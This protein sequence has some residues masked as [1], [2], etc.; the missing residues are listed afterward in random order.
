M[1]ELGHNVEGGG[2]AVERWFVTFNNI[3]YQNLA[4][5]RVGRFDP[6]AF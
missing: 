4:H 5:V 2:A 6:N 3:G 1:V